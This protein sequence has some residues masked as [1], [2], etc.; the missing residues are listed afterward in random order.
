MKTKKKLKVPPKVF[1]RLEYLRK[2]AWAL[3]CGRDAVC[4]M[5]D[6]GYISSEQID[7]MIG[8]LDSLAEKYQKKFDT[9]LK[10]NTP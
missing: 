6:M 1:S 7:L 4:K 3:R 9:L 2:A 8:V 5:E 10:K